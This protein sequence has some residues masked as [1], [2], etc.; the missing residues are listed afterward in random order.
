MKKIISPI[1][2]AALIV[3]TLCSCSSKPNADMTEENI[4]K[5]VDIAFTALKEFDSEALETYVSSSTL[6]IIMRYAESHDQFRKLGIAIF[7][8]LSYE[9]KEINVDAGTVT[10]SVTNKDLSEVAS[11][12][13]TKLMSRYSTLQL[14][15]KL[16]DDSWLDE[17]LAQ[18]TQ[19][20]SDALL[21]PEPLEFTLTITQESNHLVLSFD[22]TAENAVSGGALGAIKNSLF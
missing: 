16:S 3:L 10:V 18:L 5:T 9:I 20:I 19:G 13:T 4:T 22:D 14:L 2:I 15:A 6:G 8:N 1:L 7:E 21:N 11:S 17:N 12:F